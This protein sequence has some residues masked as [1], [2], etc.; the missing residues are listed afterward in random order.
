MSDEKVRGAPFT[1][2]SFGW[3]LLFALVIV[4]M[5]FNPTRYSYA[6]W[7]LSA[8][9]SHTFGPEHA[10]A[11]VALLGGWLIVLTATQRALGSLGL[12]VLAAFL[13]TLVWWLIDAGW[14]T[15]NSM[16]AIEWVTLSCLAV[17]LAVGMS[18]S[19]IWRR[20]TG[21]YDV[22]DVDR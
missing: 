10:V 16:N 11:G 21:Q 14:L 12:I 8:K 1:L 4:M 5:T 19:F 15:A 9:E 7:L 17:L 13:A 20:I 18:W 6:H 2:M 3:R 22:D